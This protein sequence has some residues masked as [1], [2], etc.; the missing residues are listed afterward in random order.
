MRKNHQPFWLKQLIQ[1]WDRFY[2][3]HYF[4]KHFDRLGKNAMVVHPHTVDVNGANITIGDSLYMLSTRHNP[5]S[6]TTWSGR[7]IQGNVDIGSY[8]L[9][10][11]GTSISSADRISIGDNCMFA[12]DCYISDSDWH[13]LYNRLRPFRCS[14]PI[15]LED[16]VWLGHGAKVGKGV[17]IGRNS[18]V[19]AGSVVV[20]DV[21]PNTVVGGNPAKEIKKLNPNRR[22][23]KREFLFKDSDR[24]LQMQVDL[25]RYVSGGNTLRGWIRH[26]F[27]PRKGD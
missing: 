12:A 24:F 8:C 15:V 7:G 16:N 27:F 13:G 9:I 18:V 25:E 23:L 2:I 14:K 11:P 10:S 3:R 5:V 22:M 19:A 17:T 21:P 4:S 26:K 1:S 6:I 20:K